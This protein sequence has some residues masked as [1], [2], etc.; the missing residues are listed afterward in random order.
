MSLGLKPAI[1]MCK[2]EGEI[3]EVIRALEIKG[4]AQVLH[5]IYV[6]SSAMYIQ[7]VMV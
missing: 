5:P 7:G 1:I 4:I 3:G 2:M 6:N